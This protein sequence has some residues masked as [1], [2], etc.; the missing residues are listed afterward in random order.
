MIVSRKKLAVSFEKRFLFEIFLSS[1]NR[2]KC[3]LNALQAMQ[4]NGVL[5]EEKES[6]RKQQAKKGFE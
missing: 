2:S 3:R 4:H 5:K 6:D 1:L